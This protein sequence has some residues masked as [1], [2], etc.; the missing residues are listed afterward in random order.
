MEGVISD[1]HSYSDLE[2]LAAEALPPLPS[3]FFRLAARLRV[4]SERWQTQ[5]QTHAPGDSV[6]VTISS[7]HSTGKRSD[8]ITILTPALLLNPSSFV[9]KESQCSIVAV[10]Q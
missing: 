3:R 1:S 4:S 7:G 10:A 5:T 9:R 2:S 8:S 6:N